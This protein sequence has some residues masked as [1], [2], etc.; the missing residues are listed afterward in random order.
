MNPDATIVHEFTSRA[1]G[2]DYRLKI[3]LPP[4]APPP[5]GFPVI[6]VLDGSAY[7]GLVS[8][9]VR[10]RSVFSHEIASAA[11]VGVT[12]PDGDLPSMMARRS[13]DFTP[14]VGD[15]AHALANLPG[16]QFGGL[17]GFL[18]MIENEAIAA[19]ADRA[20]IDRDRMSIFG[21]S[22]GGLAVVHAL[23]TRTALFRNW[24]ALSPSIWWD[25]RIV[26]ASEAAFADR[27][28]RGEVAPRIFIAVGSTEQT[29]PR[30]LPPDIPFT[31]AQAERWNAQ[32]RMVDNAAELAERLGSLQGSSDYC[33]R[34]VCADQQSHAGLP[35]AVANA[36]LDLALGF[37]DEPVDVQTSSAIAR[38][39]ALFDPFASDAAP[40]LVV[41][42]ARHGEQLYRRGLGLAS[43]EHGV[44]ND[45]S[46]RMR[47][48]STSKHFASLAA[49]L[50]A[51]EGKLNIDEPVT[52]ILPELPPLRGVPTLR[53]FMNHTSGYR[54]STDLAFIGSGM[55]RRPQGSL[56]AMQISQTDANFAPGE[57]QLYCNGGY[58]LLS[59]AI[60][61][62]AGQPFGEFL[63]DRIFAP[64]GMR[65]TELVPND[66]KIVPRMATMHL[67]LPDGGWQRGLL[68]ADDV[69]GEGG[70]VSTLDDMLRW[71]AHLRGPKVVGDEESWGEMTASTQVRGLQSPYGLGLYRL[72]YRGA[73]VITHGGGVPGG[74]CAMLTIPEHGL[75]IVMM[76]NGGPANLSD[77]QFR[78]VDAV[79]GD[80]LPADDT[81]HPR[82]QDFPHLLGRQY[83]ADS[84][85]LFGFDAVGDALGVSLFGSAPAPILRDC[86]TTLQAGFAGIAAGPFVWKRAAV[87][88]DAGGK[89]PDVIEME[90]TGQSDLFTCLPNIGPTIAESGAALEGFYRSDDLGADAEIR[91]SD[92]LELH[93]ATHFGCTIFV[94]EPLSDHV[95]IARLVDLPGFTMACTMAVDGSRFHLSGGR[96]RHLS[97]ERIDRVTVK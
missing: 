14:T 93:V 78:V 72:D 42:V 52:E 65:D 69:L 64:L 25:E 4:T 70:I 6:W 1:N 47:I 36:A 46:L 91:L 19:V 41:G 80:D 63:R 76:G 28:R 96:T 54:C 51:A 73:E 31:R 23:F 35:F 24:L 53:Q 49:L 77:L 30:R 9:M 10:S 34:Y 40:G 84:G 3:W 45:P 55:S 92:R 94:L 57:G 71:L 2:R 8:D 90:E 21:H 89:A 29:V 60:E 81:A 58:H 67:P 66:I 87:A 26:L 5:D 7:Q 12:Y 20:P 16:Y 39:D 15:E 44:A 68:P 38:L 17:N 22:F 33:V 85:A 13:F 83:H 27:V 79:L 48:G 18:D 59:L 56:F 32:A 43:I 50:L 62:A 75:D 88:A 37:S 61:R 11:V 95:L 82:A 86:E 97:F 74:S